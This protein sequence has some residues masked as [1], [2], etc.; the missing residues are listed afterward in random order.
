MGLTN[1]YGRGSI[2]AL[3]RQSFQKTSLSSQDKVSSASQTQRQSNASL[4]SV[5]SAP[6]P[7]VL[8]AKKTPP[9]PEQPLRRATAT[10]AFSLGAVGRRSDGIPPG[11][12]LF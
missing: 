5:S 7:P 1:G 11:L 8:G 4:Q 2:M 12:S 9:A 10:P 3:E 6:W